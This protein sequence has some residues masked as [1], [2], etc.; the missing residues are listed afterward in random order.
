MG[1]NSINR[2][3]AMF[4]KALSFGFLRTSKA[5]A[6]AILVLWSVQA[7]A[8][9]KVT[10]LTSWFAQAEHGGFY[11]A[12]ATGLY[13]HA[14]LDETLRMGGPQ[15]HG[16][17]LLLAVETDVMMRYVFPVLQSLEQRLVD[18][19]IATSCQY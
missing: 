17:Q 13:E 11:Q 4:P 7:S 1:P 15:V 6:A 16:M 9:D 8:A 5:A 12:K 3:L 14:G 18:V 19:R 2:R 10:F